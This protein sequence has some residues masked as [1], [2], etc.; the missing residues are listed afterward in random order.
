MSVEFFLIK[1]KETEFLY[2]INT[3]GINHEMVIHLKNKLCVGWS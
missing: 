1:L 2:N 3:N